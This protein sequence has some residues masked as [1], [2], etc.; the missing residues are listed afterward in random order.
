MFFSFGFAVLVHVGGLM[1]IIIASL[2]N[3]QTATW[4]TKCGI[5]EDVEYKDFEL[6]VCSIYFV[7]TTT[8]TVGYGDISPST[9]YERIYTMFLMWLGVMSFSFL[10]GQISSIM[11]SVD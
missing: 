8:A 3:D 5:G 11:Q 7:L 6:Y 4:P 1:F 2:E 10:A 9:T